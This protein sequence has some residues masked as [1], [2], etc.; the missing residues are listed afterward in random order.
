MLDLLID[1]IVQNAKTPQG[2]CAKC[3]GEG[4]VLARY[5]FITVV[6]PQCLGTGKDES[7]A[8]EA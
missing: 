6:C 1:K 7:V 3:Q 2:V 5:T 8:G 4:S